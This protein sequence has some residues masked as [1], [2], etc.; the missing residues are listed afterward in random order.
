M[1][2]YLISKKNKFL[3]STVQVYLRD[4]LDHITSSLE[5]LEFVRESLNQTHSNY[6]TKV[7]MV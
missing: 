6:L 4:V 3:T 5:K 2:A 1:A 7:S